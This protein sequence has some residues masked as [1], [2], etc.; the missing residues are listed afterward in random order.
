MEAQFYLERIEY[1]AREESSGAF[2]EDERGAP[3]KAWRE[4]LAPLVLS[5]A[6]RLNEDHSAFM[7]RLRKVDIFL[8][9]LHYTLEG[10]WMRSRRDG[11]LERDERFARPR[12]WWP[13]FAFG[14]YLHMGTSGGWEHVEVD[15]QELIRLANDYLAMPWLRNPGL[16]WLFADAILAGP[17][18]EAA[19]AARA[20]L[21]GQ[22][23]L[24]SREATLAAV[25]KMSL[26][27]LKAKAAVG[28]LKMNAI[29]FA[30]VAGALFVAPLLGFGWI[31]TA[32]LPT[33]LVWSIA[34]PS[35][36]A[37]ALLAWTVVAWVFGTLRRLLGGQDTRPESNEAKAI[38][39]QSEAEGWIEAYDLLGQPAIGVDLLRAKVNALAAKH[40]ARVPPIVLALIGRV[41]Q[42]DGAVWVP[43]PN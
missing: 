11:T 35:T 32:A 2:A 8:C 42:R 43:F 21:A 26:S 31:A 41:A 30:A 39:L 19:T 16:D 23:V 38:R 29:S 34:I 3:F 12:R 10:V 14:V 15:D 40:G 33:W 24:G 27:E 37:L 7:A 25:Q 17:V 13:H 36:L 5:E 18:L 6:M 9:D 1:F 22:A 4:A 20:E 28:R